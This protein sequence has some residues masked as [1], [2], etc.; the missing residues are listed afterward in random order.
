[1]K[2]PPSML[3]GCGRIQY[4]KY[5]DNDMLLILAC[6]SVFWSVWALFNMCPT[7]TWYTTI[8]EY[9]YYQVIGFIFVIHFLQFDLVHYIL[10][11]WLVGST[12]LVYRFCEWWLFLP[13]IIDFECNFFDH[14]HF[15]AKDLA[16][17]MKMLM[18]CTFKEISWGACYTKDV[19]TDNQLHNGFHEIR[20][21]PV[22]AGKFWHWRVALLHQRQLQVACNNMKNQTRGFPDDIY[23]P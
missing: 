14:K 5:N 4:D 3:H 2:W 15:Y 21:Y 17:T 12:F 23:G 20:A 22:V 10:F 19:D 13:C 16:E 9:P 1:M 6:R 8:L 7:W 18:T 11:Q